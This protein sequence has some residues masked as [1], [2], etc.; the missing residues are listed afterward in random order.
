MSVIHHL[1]EAKGR[2][3]NDLS[4][5]GCDNQ[6]VCFAKNAISGSRGLQTVLPQWSLLFWSH[7]DRNVI[8]YM[9]SA[10]QTCCRPVR[11]IKSYSSCLSGRLVI[12]EKDRLQQA[13]L[14]LTSCMPQ[15]VARHQCRLEP[16]HVE[17]VSIRDALGGLSG[18]KRGGVSALWSQVELIEPTFQAS[19]LCTPPPSA[20]VYTPHMLVFVQQHIVFTAASL[21]H[22]ICEALRNV[23]WHALTS[24]LF[25]ATKD[26]WHSVN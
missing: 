20:E 22:C 6:G 21:H 23:R 26:V 7:I 12:A 2:S 17:R 8:T 14:L 16:V 15:K 10:L 5:Y 19:W 1:L 3:C 13:I 24:T 25:A 18:L 4:V 11:A 9:L